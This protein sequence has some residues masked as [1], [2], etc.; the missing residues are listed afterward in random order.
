MWTDP[1]G[2]RDTFT[3]PD[4]ES[5]LN[6]SACLPICHAPFFVWLS[7]YGEEGLVKLMLLLKISFLR[8]SLTL[9]EGLAFSYGSK[10]S[11]S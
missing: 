11:N 6:L 1:E 10:L 8:V 5:D 3:W 2:Q 9:K 4:G 7:E